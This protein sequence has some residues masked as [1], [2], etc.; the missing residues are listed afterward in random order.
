MMRALVV[1]PR[2][3]LLW[4]S[5]I[6]TTLTPLPAFGC[7]HP[8]PSATTKNNVLPWPIMQ[9]GPQ[10]C[11]VLR[12]STSSTSAPPTRASSLDDVL[13]RTTDDRPGTND[14]SGL[15]LLLDGGTGE[16]LMRQGLPD[17]RKTWSAKALTDPE[18]HHLLLQVHKSFLRAGAQVITTNSYGVTPGVGFS[19]DEIAHYGNLAGQLAR[20][21]CHEYMV[22][23][24]E[25]A[26]AAA[27]E[28]NGG[29]SEEESKCPSSTSMPCF[30][31]GSLGP[32]R[33]SYRPDL[34]VP[35]HEQGVQ[36]YGTMVRALDP[37]VDAFVAETVSCVPEAKQAVEAVQRL[38]T[39][40]P[41]EKS[42]WVSFTLNSQGQLR[43][44]TPVHQAVPA[45]LD[46]A[47]SIGAKGSY[48]Y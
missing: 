10:Q 39:H 41:S 25:A 32:L 36:L 48:Q 38:A 14:N 45:L 35:D 6:A 1:V 44:G 13:E 40:S 11:T 8:H 31:L 47:R 27:T 26:A 29:L 7:F 46:F 42:C 24:E 9:R 19:N 15:L 28:P 12:S 43:D 3:S 17:D 37:H 21:A 20:Q 4:A 16:E 18:Y 23:E 30:V 34:I 22:E 33:E 5:W 2:P